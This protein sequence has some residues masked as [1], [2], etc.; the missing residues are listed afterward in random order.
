[1]E[2]KASALRGEG[3]ALFRK[4]V[5]DGMKDAAESLRAAGV[6]ANFLLFLE[7]TDALKYVADHAQG[8]VIFMDNG[9][10]ASTRVVQGVLSMGAELPPAGTAGAAP[11]P[12][13]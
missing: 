8:K 3:L 9:A 4:N 2:K 11:A 13:R 7:Y 12:A 6:D 5:A 10:A 1:A